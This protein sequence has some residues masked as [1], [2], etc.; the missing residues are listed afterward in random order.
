MK[1][2]N[3][4]NNLFFFI[5]KKN[6]W[7]SYTTILSCIPIIFFSN[8]FLFINV[9]SD[10][11]KFIR[12]FY[13]IFIHNRSASQSLRPRRPPSMTLPTEPAPLAQVSLL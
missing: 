9:N 7:D 2:H 1:T 11:Y 12:F 8:I 5:Y 10:K 13:N 6:I 3:M 4:T